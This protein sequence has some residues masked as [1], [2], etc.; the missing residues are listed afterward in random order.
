MTLPSPSL[1]RLEQDK[2][3]AICSGLWSSLVTIKGQAGGQRETC[4]GHDKVDENYKSLA[5]FNATIVKFNLQI[6]TRH[7]FK[8]HMVILDEDTI[9]LESLEENWIKDVVLDAFLNRL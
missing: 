7:L 9:S 8:L 2:V 3:M 1:A 6:A 4:R 5:K